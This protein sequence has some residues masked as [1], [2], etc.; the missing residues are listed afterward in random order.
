MILEAPTRI[1]EAL[2]TLL[3]PLGRVLGGSWEALGGVW[4]LFGRYVGAW[5]VH[6]KRIIEILKNHQKQCKVL[7]KSRFGGAAIDQKMS[8][9]GK[10]GLNLMLS[11]LVRVQ[12]G[13]KRGKLTLLGGLRGTKLAIKWALGL[14]KEAPSSSSQGFRRRPRNLKGALGAA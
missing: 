8:L 9:E 11:W 5:R 6:L 3:E 4:E 14:P 1:S 2:G 13:A 12:V 7:Q 10:L